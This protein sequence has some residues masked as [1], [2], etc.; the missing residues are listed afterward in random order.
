MQLVPSVPLSSLEGPGSEQEC[1]DRNS[2]G[3][4]LDT[5]VR[6]EGGCVLRV[7]VEVP[8]FM[9][10]VVL[11]VVTRLEVVLVELS[12]AIDNQS[13]LYYGEKTLFSSM[14]VA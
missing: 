9:S 5:G 2:G 3:E 1:I 4:L 13:K 11:I 7:V 14:Y 8:G 10:T 6:D 12:V